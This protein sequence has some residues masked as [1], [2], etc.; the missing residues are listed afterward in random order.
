MPKIAFCAYPVNGTPKTY[1]V[2]FKKF[3]ICNTSGTWITIKNE[4]Q[5]FNVASANAGAMLGNYVSGNFPVG[6]YNKIRV[7]ISATFGIK[8]FV[9]DTN[10]GVNRTYYTTTSG[11]SSVAGNVA[12][13]DL[14][15][16][17]NVLQLTITSLGD[18][19]PAGNTLSG[20][21]I[22]S[23]MTEQESFTITAGATQTKNLYVDVT[24]T[25]QL[26]NDSNLY[27]GPFNVDETP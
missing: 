20:G 15:S 23:E 21:N 11:T 12:E 9:Y 19:P 14:P 3:E 7:T 16:D 1:N 24:N 18:N 5:T 13:A 17:Y 22:I 2:T 4:D 25:L 8:G 6:T 10:T 27:P 26:Q